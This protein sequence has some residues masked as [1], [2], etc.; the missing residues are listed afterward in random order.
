MSNTLI[1]TDLVARDASILLANNLVMANL[2]NRNHEAKFANKIGDTV[3][4]KVPP[5]VASR[6][7]IDDSSAI[8][9]SAI[10]ESSVDL[11]LTEQP[12]VA[13]TLSSEQR[14]LELDDFNTV[15]TQPAVSAIREAIEEHLIKVGTQGFQPYHV[16]GESSDPSTLAH[17]IAGRKQLQDNGAPME[18]RVGVLST[19]AEASMLAL[20][21]FTSVDY[22]S[23]NPMALQEAILG[24]KFGID[25]Y[26]SQNCGTMD[27][28]G[29]AQVSRMAATEVAAVTTITVDNGS[30]TSSGT[31]TR[32]SRFTIAG[33]TQVYTVTA[34]AVA[35]SGAI[36]LPIT[37]GLVIQADDN[38]A[39]SWKTAAKENLLFVRNSLAGAIV[40]PAP[41]MVGSSIAF[42]NGIG[43]RVSMSSAT[44][45]LSDQ[46][47]FDCYLGG[48]VIQ[49]K[50]G[51]VIGGV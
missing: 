11:A 17:L 37:P 31:I 2:V 10:T 40:A 48:Q 43:I 45:S 33:D 32:G 21:Q 23:S 20:D 5:V 39:I 15:V 1:T 25:W 38:D 46:I 49:V 36:E 19:V 4:V 29:T 13:V 16:G 35:S 42:Y 6:D 26:T 30:G 14:S 50:G 41:L 18:N 24:R 3:R 44:A 27:Q 12:Y 47:V 7:F 8:T 9:D 34:D 28:S 22:G 51:C